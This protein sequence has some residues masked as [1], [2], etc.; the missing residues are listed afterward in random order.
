MED[1]VRLASQFHQS[2]A[3]ERTTREIKKTVRFRRGNLLRHLLPL[4]FFNT[5]KIDDRQ[6]ARFWLTNLQPRLSILR[7]RETGAQHFVTA[8]ALGE[9]LLQCRCIQSSRRVD[10][11]G[12]VVRR[13]V[14]R[15]LLQ[16][17]QPLLGK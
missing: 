8:H 16:H 1:Q 10:P 6:S 15:E 11:Y 5:G 2:R 7:W 4:A 9:N 12:N 3:H 13:A 14:R 17:P